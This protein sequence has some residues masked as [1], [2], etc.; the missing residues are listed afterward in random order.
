M[1][2]ELQSTAEHGPELQFRL[3]TAE[4][5]P[6][7]GPLNAQLIV[8][9]GHRNSMTVPQLVERMTAWLRGEYQAVIVESSGAIDGYALYRREADHLYV[10]QIFVRGEG[11]RRGIGRRLLQW[12]AENAGHG[13]LRIRIDVLVGNTAARQFWESLGFRDYCLTMERE[14]SANR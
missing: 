13:T 1:T 4:D 12:L 6:A 5:G 7:L 9:E 10:R 14:L 2:N 8:D 11:R 3:A